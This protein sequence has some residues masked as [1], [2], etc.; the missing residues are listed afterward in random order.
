MR[1]GSAAHELQRYP[2]YILIM[3]LHIEIW[4]TYN[5]ELESKLELMQSDLSQTSL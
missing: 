1:E 2:V 4:N 3:S 5:Q